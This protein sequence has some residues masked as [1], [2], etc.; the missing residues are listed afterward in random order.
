MAWHLQHRIV[1]FAVILGTLGAGSYLFPG[2][3]IAEFRDSWLDSVDLLTAELGLNSNEQTEQV[4]K[5]CA[6]YNL[7]RPITASVAPGA[8]IQIVPR[9]NFANS[10]SPG[11]YPGNNPN[12]SSLGKYPGNR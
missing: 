6:N 5:P 1:V 12:G 8:P 3:P 10:V 9:P 11:R 4:L 7:S 2:N